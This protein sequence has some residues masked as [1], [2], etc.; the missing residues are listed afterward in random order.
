[1][2][3]AL[4]KSMHWSDTEIRC[5][6]TNVLKKSQ[7]ALVKRETEGFDKEHRLAYN[8]REVTRSENGWTY[9]VTFKPTENTHTLQADRGRD[10]RR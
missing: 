9:T 2:T 3:N 4:T 1:M 10:D 7:P 8:D 5:K 6:T